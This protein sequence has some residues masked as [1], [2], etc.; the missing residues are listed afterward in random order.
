MK[1]KL[2]YKLIEKAMS[3]DKTSIDRI[4]S[5]YQPYINTLASRT[6]YDAEG[7]EFIGVNVE[8]KDHLTRKLFQV[9]HSFKINS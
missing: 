1:S 6:V 9:I 7:N 4:V 3:G 8:L 5:I 2:N